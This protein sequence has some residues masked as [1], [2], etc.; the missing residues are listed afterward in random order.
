MWLSR[1]KL[2]P[3][4]RFVQQD[5]ANPYE[6]HRTVMQAFPG[7]DDG[8]PGRVLFRVDQ[9]RDEEE[10]YVLLVQSE[11]EPDWD[12]LSDPSDYLLAPAESKPL[13]LPVV[14]GQRLAFRLRANPTVKKKQEGKRNGLRLGVIGEENQRAWLERKGEDG[15]FRLIGVQG[16]EEGLAKTR[17]GKGRDRQSMSHLA[18]RFEGVLEVVDP[19]RF[20]E[21]VRTGVGSA[22]GLGFGLFSVAPV[23]AS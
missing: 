9:T 19:E 1:L 5:L 21:T 17:A 4:C 12:R 20:I 3:L 18:V 11:K 6:M 16:I 22:K 2:N 7:Q 15:G 10:P 14:A 13:G 8:G 23:Q